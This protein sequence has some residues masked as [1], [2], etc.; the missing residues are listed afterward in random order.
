MNFQINFTSETFLVLQMAT[1]TPYIILA[2]CFDWY[3]LKLSIPPD[4]KLQES[5]LELEKSVLW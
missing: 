4:A 2:S 5:E 3:K 1:P